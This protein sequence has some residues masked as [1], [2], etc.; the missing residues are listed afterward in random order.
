MSTRLSFRPTL[1]S[2]REAH[3]ARELPAWSQAFLRGPGGNLGIADPLRVEDNICLLTEID[4]ND[5][6]PCSGPDADFD[7]PVPLDQY[8]RTVEDMT[9]AFQAGWDA[10]PLFIQLTSLLVLDGNHRREALL[11]LERGRYSAVLL[12]EP[13][14]TARACRRSSVVAVLSG[15]GYDSG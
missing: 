11:R 8:E 5:V 6:Y 14:A 9:G 12:D 15:Q 3:T 13:S 4:L 1:A 10:P 7:F 2:A